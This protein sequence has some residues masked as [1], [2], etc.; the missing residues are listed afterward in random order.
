MDDAGLMLL[1]AVVEM[2]DGFS[3]SELASWSGSGELGVDILAVI[4][5]QMSICLLDTTIL[6]H[7][8]HMSN[9]VQRDRGGQSRKHYG[10]S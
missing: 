7:H 6:R 10:S 4:L 1:A 5:V 9:R 2:L 8:T 3:L